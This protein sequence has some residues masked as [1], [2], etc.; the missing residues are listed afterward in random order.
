MFSG[1]DCWKMAIK[2][3]CPRMCVLLE[4]W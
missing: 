3:V 1:W 4:V 2:M